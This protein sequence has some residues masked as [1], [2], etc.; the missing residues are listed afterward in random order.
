MI[1]Q[2]YQ[3]IIAFLNLAAII[4][5]AV[6]LLVPQHKA[7]ALVPVY[8]AAAVA[9]LSAIAV[10][11]GTT[12]SMTSSLSYKEYTLDTILWALVK[13]LILTLVADVVN[14]IISGNNGEP[15]FIRDLGLFVRNFL[16]Q[17]S[18]YFLENM[19]SPEMRKLL[20]EPW[21][22][23]NGF[24]DPLYNIL[25]KIRRGYLNPLAFPRCTLLED[26]LNGKNP[27]G[28]FLTDF[29]GGGWDAWMNMIGNPMNNPLG[30]IT[31]MGSKME[32]EMANAEEKAKTEAQMNNGFISNKICA[33]PSNSDENPFG[34]EFC[35]MWDTLSPG[36]WIQEQLSQH[37]GTEIRTL[38]IADE[39]SEILGAMAGMAM[40][41]MVSGIT[42]GTHGGADW[43]SEDSTGDMADDE[44]GSSLEERINHYIETE[45]DYGQNINTARANYQTAANTYQ[46]AYD[47]LTSINADS[48]SLPGGPVTIAACG[49]QMNNF[50]SQ[51][52]IDTL[53]NCAQSQIQANQNK[54]SALQS[55]KN[56][57]DTNLVALISMRDRLANADSETIA[58]I[59]SEFQNLSSSLHGDGQVSISENEI[60]SSQ[61]AISDA[62][63]LLSLCQNVKTTCT[64]ENPPPPPAP[65]TPPGDTG[66]PEIPDAPPAPPA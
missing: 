33:E 18:G 4:F 6:F 29:R 56:Q 9:E 65:P 23:L 15:Y 49:I 25:R 51:N 13:A 28:H 8:D 30:Q 42:S 44:L 60:S 36:K 35:N 38:E 24:G 10:S 47:C 34:E 37:T 31:T 39:L 57:S 1:P 66:A 41:W 55:N 32:Q 43:G 22:L 59:E 26:L 52:N 45:T 46:N 61:Q 54:A 19:I 16:A 63:K 62:Q 50:D 3:K 40:N 48:C 12:A 64:S 17:A 53:T 5:S 2:R 20:C 11:S 58:D 14:N 27:M 7:Q 21:K